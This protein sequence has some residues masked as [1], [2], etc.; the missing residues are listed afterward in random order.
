M[1]TMVNNCARDKQLKNHAALQSSDSLPLPPYYPILRPVPLVL[2]PPGGRMDGS[3]PSSCFSMQ[4]LRPRSCYC[5]LPDSLPRPRTS[6]S[7][8]MSLGN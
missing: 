4:R 5:Y 6:T 3:Q 2:G 1:A 8:G 7:H